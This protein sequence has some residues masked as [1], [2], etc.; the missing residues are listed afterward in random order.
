MPSQMP[1]GNPQA[2]HESNHPRLLW[3]PAIAIQR[4]GASEHRGEW[5]I[6]KGVLKNPESVEV[7]CSFGAC[8]TQECLRHSNAPE[9]RTTRETILHEK[10]LQTDSMHEQST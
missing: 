3:L 2:R 4:H 8:N 5:L 10:N 9:K 6:H 7:I 1:P